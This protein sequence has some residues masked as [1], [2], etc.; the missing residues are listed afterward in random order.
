MDINKS[1]AFFKEYHEKY[2][3]DRIITIIPDELKFLDDKLYVSIL[4]E[5]YEKCTNFYKGFNFN[6]NDLNLL[7]A[8][9]IVYDKNIAR[10]AFSLYNTYRITIKW[11]DLSEILNSCDE[12][13]MVEHSLSPEKTLKEIYIKKKENNRSKRLTDN[14]LCVALALKDAGYS[15]DK[16]MVILKSL[17]LN[18]SRSTVYKQINETVSN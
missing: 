18:I 13:F 9:Y 11:L 1:N 5:F 17:G 12:W 6:V 10:T 15:Y 16:I 7:Y 4:N 8:S 3:A 14:E 2:R